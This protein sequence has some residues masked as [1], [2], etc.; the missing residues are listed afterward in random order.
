[1][2]IGGLFTAIHTTLT[3]MSN[4][5]TRL[6][7][8]SENIANAEKVPDKNGKVYKRKIVVSK[9]FGGSEP[10]RFR[11]ELNLRMRT[12]R[13]DHMQSKSLSGP[14]G[15]PEGG[16]NVKVVSQEGFK[17]EYNPGHPRADEN[18]YVKMPKINSVEE[19]VDLMATSRTYEANVT[20]LNAAK[21]MAKRALEI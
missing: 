5:I 3:G 11:N 10:S 21:A 20:V 16:S 8:V 19:M 4:Q 2:K 17:L 13:S 18:G 14:G 15:M 12:T 7:A 9:N 1:M 6:D